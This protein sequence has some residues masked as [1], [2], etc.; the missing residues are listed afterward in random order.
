MALESGCFTTVPQISSFL[1]CFLGLLGTYT[2]ILVLLLLLHFPGHKRKVKG[3]ES[4]SW[5][6]THVQFFRP[7]SRQWYK[8]YLADQ[9]GKG[10]FP[11]P[12]SVHCQC[13]TTSAGSCR[14][15]W[16]AIL[17]HTD[18]FLAQA[19]LFLNLFIWALQESLVR[20]PNWERRGEPWT[21]VSPLWVLTQYFSALFALPVTPE[22]VKRQEPF[23]R[24]FLDGRRPPW[25]F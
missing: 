20:A 23:V 22:F 3:Q 19:P 4:D 21:H 15:I 7:H 25:L 1:L 11:T 18:A 13:I 2:L 12:D 17:F 5:L 8:L 6:K 24:Q 16:P 14:S 9:S 10:T